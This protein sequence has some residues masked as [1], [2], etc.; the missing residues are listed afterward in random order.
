MNLSSS[1][2]ALIDL[3]R[4]A[5]MAHVAYGRYSADRGYAYD[6]FLLLKAILDGLVLSQRPHR[7]LC[8]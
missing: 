2:I 6:R 4:R 8:R 3:R 1:Y 5:E 7:S